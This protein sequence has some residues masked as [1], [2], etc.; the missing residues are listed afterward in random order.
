MVLTCLQTICD[1]CALTG[2]P[3]HPSLDCAQIKRWRRV[4][5]AIQ[6]GG[7]LMVPERRRQQGLQVLI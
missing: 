7:Y 2:R 6:F 5:G 3:D 4:A 1:L